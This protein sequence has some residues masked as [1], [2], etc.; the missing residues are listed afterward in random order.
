MKTL[1]SEYEVTKSETKIL[2]L[3]KL[4]FEYLGCS[5]TTGKLLRAG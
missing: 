5:N 4:E 2:K 3:L 1:I